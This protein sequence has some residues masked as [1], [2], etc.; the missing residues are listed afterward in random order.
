MNGPTHSARFAVLDGGP[1]KGKR[2]EIAPVQ[3]AIEIPGTA[4]VV[5]H[6]AYEAVVVNDP[7]TAMFSFR[8]RTIP[9]A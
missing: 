7:D 6:Y 4:E 9:D 5:D 1:H 2:V 3:L 8:E